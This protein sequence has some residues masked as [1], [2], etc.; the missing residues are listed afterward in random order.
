M[1]DIND[2]AEK[3]SV[4]PFEKELTRFRRKVVIEQCVK[5]GASSVLE[6][7]CGLEPLFTDYTA[8]ERMTIVEP[9]RAFAENARMMAAD[10]GVSDKVKIVFDSIESASAGLLEDKEAFDF[11]VVGAVLHEVDE[12]KAMLS[13]VKD[14]C[15]KNTTVHINVPNA[16]SLHRLVALE[17]GM[18]SN[19]HDLSDMQIKM[20]QRRTYDMESLQDEIRAAGF[21]VLDSGY[22][23]IKPFTH[24]QMKK[25]LD[26]N[27]IDERVLEGLNGITKYIPEYGA[28]MFVNVKVR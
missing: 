9:S 27:I 8:Y 2:Y 12:P 16:K 3:Y 14:L 18:I 13:A 22:Y 6:V 4:E 1:R 25:C 15:G 11:I 28:E 21:E 10:T 20:Q 19:E 24:E 7:G 5:Y 17:S 23:F 26:A